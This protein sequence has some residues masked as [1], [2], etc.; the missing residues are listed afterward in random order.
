VTAEPARAQALAEVDE[1]T[2]ARAKR[3]EEPARRALVERYQR[4]VHALLFRMLGGRGDVAADLAQETFVRVFGALARF[5]PA[6]PARLSTWILTIATRL[7][8]NELR[9][10]PHEP[11]ADAEV[12]VPGGARPD[13]ELERRAVAAAVRRAIGELKPDY[14]AVLILREYHE[15]EYEDIAVALEIDLGTVKSRLARAR[16]ALREALGELGHA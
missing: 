8:L 5:S 15:L 12:E 2:L 4:P 9:R 6:G 7:A 11:L 1:I 16:G 3:G 10:R 14:R 13:R